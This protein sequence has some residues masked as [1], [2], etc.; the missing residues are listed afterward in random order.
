MGAK[1]NAVLPFIYSG[2]LFGCL[3]FGRKINT[4][5][6]GLSFLERGRF[7]LFWFWNVGSIYSGSVSGRLYWPPSCLSLSHLGFRLFH[8][9]NSRLFVR[10]IGFFLNFFMCGGVRW[11]DRQMFWT[12]SIVRCAIFLSSNGVDRKHVSSHLG[13]WRPFSLYF[14]SLS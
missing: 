13:E 6:R 1:Y 9:K 3:D 11:I 5:H 7:I 14:R 2:L 8:R 10:I 4:L 12:V